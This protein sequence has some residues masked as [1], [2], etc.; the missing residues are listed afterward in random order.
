M[1]ND[2]RQWPV[3]PEILGMYWRMYDMELMA[4]N[5]N[6]A[7]APILATERAAA[8]AEMREAMLAIYERAFEYN[9]VVQDTI[10]A[11]RALPI[12][13]DDALRKVV[14]YAIQTQEAI[15]KVSG[16]HRWITYESVLAECFGSKP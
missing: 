8:A 3:T 12:P 13:G 14:E 10:D 2:E 5:L 4:K 6:A 1:P 9:W 16:T 15:P 11:I 7:L